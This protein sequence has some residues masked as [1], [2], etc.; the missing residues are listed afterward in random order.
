MVTREELDAKM[1][2]LGEKARAV[3]RERGFTDEQI[4][5]ELRKSKRRKRNA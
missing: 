2:A 3:L 1:I 5:A 4:E